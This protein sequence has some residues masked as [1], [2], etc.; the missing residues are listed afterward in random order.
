MRAN[1]TLI[2]MLHTVF[3]LADT[4]PLVQAMKRGRYDILTF[5]TMPDTII[6]HIEKD[7]VNIPSWQHAYIT[8]FSE[9]FITDKDMGSLYII[10]GHHLPSMIL[11]SGF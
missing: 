5:V 1:E 10:I 6:E 11:N 9:Y 2:H 3:D 4:D 7:N 8:M